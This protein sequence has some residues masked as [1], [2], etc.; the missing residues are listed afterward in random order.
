MPWLCCFVKQAAPATC[1]HALVNTEALKQD[2]PCV[3]L[4]S[5]HHHTGRFQCGPMSQLKLLWQS[6]RW[7]LWMQPTLA[8]GAALAS[9]RQHVCRWYAAS[10]SRIRRMLL[11]NCRLSHP[12][13]CTDLEDKLKLL[14]AFIAVA[15]TG[16]AV[17]A[18]YFA[19]QNG[20][21]PVLAAIKA[22][23]H[24]QLLPSEAEVKILGRHA[25][26]GSERPALSSTA[27]QSSAHRMRRR[28]DKDVLIGHGSRC[29]CNMC[30]AEL[31][32][33]A[34]MMLAATKQMLDGCLCRSMMCRA[35]CLAP[36]GCMKSCKT[37]HQSHDQSVAVCV[38]LNLAT[39]NILW[40]W[41]WLHSVLRQYGACTTEQA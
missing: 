24:G 30:E 16:T 19:Q 41:S 18:A 1:M 13:C 37:T 9:S 31:L 25:R 6:V 35:L 2:P 5:F 29:A 23:T 11:V 38:C 39:V 4:R 36:S 27:Q 10:V 26:S 12:P 32:G 17:A 15:H 7:V 8:T 21:S 22:Q 20:S 3:V 14:V 40:P 33:L 34:T 28:L